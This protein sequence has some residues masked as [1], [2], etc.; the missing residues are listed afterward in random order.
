VRL[1][2]A[3]PEA[4]ILE[5]PAV[6]RLIRMA[7]ASDMES[8]DQ[9]PAYVAHFEDFL[10][11]VDVV[12]ELIEESLDPHDVHITVDGRPVVNPVTFYHAL[13]CYRESLDVPDQAAYCAQQAARVGDAGECPDRGCLVHCQFICSRCIGLSRERGAPAISTQ[14]LEL[15]RQAE[16]DW[17]PNLRLE[18]SNT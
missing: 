4:Q 15:A 1:S 18:T 11:S 2:I 12:A 7:Q 9:G 13:V 10:Q 16:V 8:D 6:L 14:L 5:A 17:C 3:I